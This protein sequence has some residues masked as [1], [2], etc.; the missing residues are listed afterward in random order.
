MDDAQRDTEKE[1]PSPP[2]VEGVEG[3]QTTA[4]GEAILAKMSWWEQADLWS[5]INRW[6]RLTGFPPPIEREDVT[7]LFEIVHARVKAAAEQRKK[8]RVDQEYL[9]QRLDQ[10]LDDLGNH[11]LLTLLVE[12]LEQLNP[13]WSHQ[14]LNSWTGQPFDYVEHIEGEPDGGLSDANRV[15]SVDPATSESNLPNPGRRGQDL[16][17][18][19]DGQPLRIEIRAE[20]RELHARMLDH[21][22]VDPT[23]EDPGARSCSSVGEKLRVVDPTSDHQGGEGSCSATW[24]VLGP[25]DHKLSLIHI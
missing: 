7:T 13:G 18:H 10:E 15:L 1:S 21:S 24:A 20:A 16:L 8:E 5:F 4:A 6:K 14:A 23:G 11:E 19:P 22:G 17:L 2:A 9:A 12:R 25:H 3:D